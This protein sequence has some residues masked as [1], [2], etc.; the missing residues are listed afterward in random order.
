MIEKKLKKQGVVCVEDVIH[1]IYTVGPQFKKVNKFLWPF[2]LS[3]PRGG[4]RDIGIPLV[5]LYRLLLL[6][7]VVLTRRNNCRP[8]VHR[9]WRRWQPRKAHQ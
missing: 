2:K 6:L 1:E 3:S 9:Q 5:L 4:F 7:F 8:S